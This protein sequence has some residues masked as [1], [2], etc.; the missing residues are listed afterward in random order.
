MT[1]LYS[2]IRYMELSFSNSSFAYVLLGSN[3]PTASTVTIMIYTIYVV[4]VQE[5][6][7]RICHTL[8]NIT[9]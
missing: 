7:I 1:D 4:A 2:L 5:S 8:R 6:I 3:V 9:G